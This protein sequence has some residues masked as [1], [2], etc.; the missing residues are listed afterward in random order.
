MSIFSEVK[1]PTRVRIVS[2]E[3][4]LP[5]CQISVQFC[6][7]TGATNLLSPRHNSFLT[8]P[9]VN[10]PQRETATCTHYTT[11]WYS[12]L[13]SAHYKPGDYLT[14]NSVRT[15][16]YHL[17]ILGSSTKQNSLQSSIV[18]VFTN[19]YCAQYSHHSLKFRFQ[20]WKQF[21]HRFRTQLSAT[22]R[23]WDG[24]LII[25]YVLDGQNIGI[26]NII[27]NT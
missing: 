12:F 16:I 22:H 11:R 14:D 18:S 7:F 24:I 10:T 5:L 26:P 4:L 13:H 3:E 25:Q 8:V 23:Y 20:W 27:K 19:S 21:R 17:R 2:Y 9:H 1:K 15:S 6:C